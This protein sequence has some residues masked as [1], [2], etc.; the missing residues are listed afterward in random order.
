MNPAIFFEPNGYSPTADGWIMGRQSAGRGFLRAAVA[1]RGEGPVRG[2][3]AQRESSEA[4]RAAVAAIDPEASV[5]WHAAHRVD[6]LAE[7]GVLYRPDQVLG[8]AARL[9]LRAGPAAYALCGVTHTLATHGTL[10]AVAK[11]VT[12]PVMPWDA[13]ICTSQAAHAVVTAVLDHE[14]DY[15]RWRCGIARAPERPLLPVIPL[16]VH[17]ADFDA[18]PGARERAR[19]ACG[20]SDD[21]I[22]VLSAGRLSFNGKAHPYPAFRALEAVAASTGRKLVLLIAGQAYTDKIRQAYEAAAA[23]VCPRVRT[24]IVDGK[25]TAAYRGAWAAADIFLSLADSI[26]ETFG[27]TPVEAMAAGLP[28]LISDWN[29]Y[30]D[31]VRDG[32]DGFRVATWAPGPG[33]GGG[34]AQA[35]E[36]GFSDYEDYLMRC[37]AAVSVDPKA[38]NKGLEALVLDGQLRR[39]MGAAGR[40]RALA[41]FDWRVVYGRYQALW[42]EQGE[43]RLRAL[44]QAGDT[45]L[46]APRTGSDHMGPFDT[47]AAF[48]TRHI[49]PETPVALVEDLTTEAYNELIDEPLLARAAIRSRLFELVRDALRHGPRTVAEAAAAADLD[50]PLAREAVARLAKLGIV[51]LG[52]PSAPS[53]TASARRSDL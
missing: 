9:R 15:Q 51:Q 1:G 22:V 37:S 47:F 21:E 40:E 17:C 10:D 12:E 8:P 30:K 48:P 14:A 2:V 20:I 27:L 44:A 52:E 46:G 25:D 11:I 4:F 49:D 6:R 38:L 42:A 34:I 36:A 28:A 3:S 19:A 43:R 53:A 32:L 23:R 13:L 39:R 26:Q 41:D 16:G 18:A 35:Y 45:H 24:L 33:A 50:E 7:I 5:E 31:T 29:G